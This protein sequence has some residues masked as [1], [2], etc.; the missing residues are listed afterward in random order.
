MNEIMDMTLR[1]T[2]GNGRYEVPWIELRGEG[3][4]ADDAR[5]RLDMNVAHGIFDAVFKAA[6]TEFDLSTLEIEL[7][8]ISGEVKYRL[9]KISVNTPAMLK[10]AAASIFQLRE[11][12]VAAA[13][14][15]GEQMA[16]ARFG[17]LVRSTAGAKAFIDELLE[18][19]QS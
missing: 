4:T 17:F 7:N 3:K 19:A 14:P 16:V 13:S 2:E 1:V 15:N 18:A 8:E 5:T 6:G 11:T 10:A 9:G 12:L